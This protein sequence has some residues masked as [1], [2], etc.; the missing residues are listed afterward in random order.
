MTF[1]VNC[2]GAKIHYALFATNQTVWIII[3]IDTDYNECSDF[4]HDCPVNATCVNS[5]GSYSCRCPVGYRLNGKNC[6][7]L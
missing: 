7:G 5:D 4:S 2:I 1:I 3:F 6:S